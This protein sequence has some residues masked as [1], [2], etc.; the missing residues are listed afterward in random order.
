VGELVL[1]VGGTRSGK[2]RYAL[3]RAR[4]S[5]G[6]A[7]TFVATALPGDP[8]LDER[9]A[10][11]RRARPAAWATLD[12]AADL[13]RTIA[14]ARGGDLVLVDSLTLWVSARIQAS[15]DE[16]ADRVDRAL[17]AARARQRG[18]IFVSDEVGLGIVPPNA[19]ARRFADRMGT[20]AQRVAREADEVV[21]V[22]AG[23][24]LPLGGPPRSAA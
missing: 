5:A 13:A 9:I 24:P 22:V 19:M 11:H 1:V 7:V 4:R 12:A 21:L 8:E 18:C 15:D 20:L 10:A 2:S 17:A 23:R 3:E 16:M 14:A 6:D